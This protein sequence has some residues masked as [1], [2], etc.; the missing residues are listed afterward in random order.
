MNGAKTICSINKLMMT[1]SI[2]SD[3]SPT[4]IRSN[5]WKKT[6]S[7]VNHLVK[8]SA[9]FI[10]PSLLQSNSIVNAMESSDFKAVRK[11]VYDL[12]KSNPDK[13]PTLLRLAW[14]SSG[15]YD[16]ISK[17]GGSSLGTIRFKEELSHGANN[18]LDLAVSWLE[19][20]H[21]SNPTISYADLYTLSGGKL[22]KIV[23]TFVNIYLH[24]HLLLV[25]A[26]EALGGPIIGWRAGRVDSITPSDVTPDGRL[27]SADKGSPANT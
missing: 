4:T 7:I 21:L 26:I 10:F 8:G 3:P 27:P 22:I 13:G 19:P 18:G 20:I 11:A 14:H 1:D 25:V 24:Y 17:T 5:Y 15:T 16:K 12:V 9:I 23:M 2:R 6:T